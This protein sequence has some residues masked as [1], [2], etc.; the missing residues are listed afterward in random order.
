M[1]CIQQWKWNIAT[2]NNMG[3]SLEILEIE[4]MKEDVIKFHEIKSKNMQND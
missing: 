3:N 2:S 1:E 4:A